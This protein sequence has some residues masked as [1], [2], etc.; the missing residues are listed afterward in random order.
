MVRLFACF[1][2]ILFSVTIRAQTVL[3]GK[4][5]DS[6][7]HGIANLSIAYQEKGNSIILGFTRT[8]P[9][10]RFSLHVKSK[11]DSLLLTLSH[12][13]YGKKDTV[14][15]NK[16]AYHHISMILSP[17]ILK[18]VQVGPPPIY[19]RKDTI[20]YTVE[21]FTDKQDRV[22]GD[23]IKKLPGIEMVGDRILYQGKAIQKYMV[24]NLDLMGGRYGMINKNLPADAVKKVQLIEND[25]P[26]KILDSVVFSDRASLNLELKKYTTTGSGELAVGYKPVLWKVNLTP[27]TFNRTFQSL[28][29]FQS[30]NIGLDVS[31]QTQMYYTGSN[32]IIDRAENIIR[33]G[34]SFMSLRHVAV[35]GFDQRKWL[36]NRIFMVSSNVLK[37]LKD[38][39][40]IKGNITYYHDLQKREG[41][42]YSQIFAPEQ[43]VIISEDI[44]NRYRAHNLEGGMALEKNEKKIYLKN[45][46]RFRRRWN[47]D[48]GQLLFN[49]EEPIQQNKMYRDFSIANKLSGAKHVGK[50]LV[51]LSSL[52]SYGETPQQLTVVPGQFVDIVNNGMPYDRLIQ[53]V[54]IK[55]FNTENAISFSRSINGWLITPKF[56]IGY[57]QQQLNSDVE[58]AKGNDNWILG[59][60]FT[61]DQRAGQLKSSL[62]IGL[63][64]KWRK[65]MVTL[66][67]PY[68]LNVNDLRQNGVRSDPETRS[69]LNPGGSVRLKWNEYNEVSLS[70]S[71]QTHYSGL[72][73]RYAAYIISNYRNIQR[74][75]PRL[76][77]NNAW[78]NSVYY[79]YRNTLDA[80]FANLS[81][82]YSR[83][84]RDYIFR[85]TI[86]DNGLNTIS[87]EDQNSGNWSHRWSGNGSKLFSSIG[88]T[89]KING[90]IGF[91]RSD[92][93]LNDI[94]G[95]RKNMDYGGGIEIINSSWSFLSVQYKTNWGTSISTL[96]DN[97][98]Y[99]VMTNVHDFDV[100]VYPVENHSFT[101]NNAFYI[102][103]VEAQKNQLFMD[104]IYRWTL[105]KTRTDLEFSC[106][107]LLNNN[108]YIQRFNSD[109]AVIES[110]F[111]L[112]PRQFLISYKFRF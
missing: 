10:G 92:Y 47:D 95:Q 90:K 26:I 51:S 4:V 83:S 21:S 81:Y 33:S 14:L 75:R 30:N 44:H 105:K 40:E 13:S 99:R 8:G 18:E 20:N 106:I 80:V 111:D 86:D 98:R 72:T 69:F 52:I 88:T 103:N 5:V 84:H 107:N 53:Q 60:D 38:S 6:V 27:M 96:A 68:Y 31:Q 77:E 36:D 67:I 9:E 94:M 42:T 93:L 43:E 66:N 65:W 59:N 70:G 71:Y 19:K 91:G 11:Q 34:G 29:T 110:Y 35:P 15:V 58:L 37:K 39:T 76:L 46:F 49:N 108:Q 17:Q 63:Q 22:I 16:T 24:N 3:S 54:H 62:N 104:I 48:E 102:T 64:R 100:S 109:Y 78:H 2:L 23:I 55:Q 61:N 7:G 56:E 57:Q 87:I 89:V 85:N 45:D 82:A 41:Y 1:L 32:G 28:H 73:N 101:W 12:L 50:Q 74:Y 112:R 79:R 97:T 25:Q